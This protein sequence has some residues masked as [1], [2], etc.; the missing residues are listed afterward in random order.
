MEISDELSPELEA[1]VV[2]VHGWPQHRVVQECYV[3]GL[4]GDTSS[5]NLG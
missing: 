1:C 3:L 2:R 5:G 4:A